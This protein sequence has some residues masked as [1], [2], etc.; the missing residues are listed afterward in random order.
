MIKNLFSKLQK[1][2]LFYWT[3]IFIHPNKLIQFS[4]KIY[5][6]VLGM[7]LVCLGMGTW[8]GLFQTPPDYQQ[9]EVFRLIY[10]HVPAAI[11]S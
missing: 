4:K 10:V 11:W 9:G 2:Y 7:S 8:G 6:S 5:P 1:I 3:N